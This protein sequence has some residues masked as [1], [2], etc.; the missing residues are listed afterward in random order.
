MFNLIGI[1]IVAKRYSVMAKY[2]F[3]LGDLLTFQRDA[4][5]ALVH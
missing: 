5:F 2:N 3:T 4:M 1:L